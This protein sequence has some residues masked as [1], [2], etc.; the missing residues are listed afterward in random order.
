MVRKRG[1]EIHSYKEF[2]VF[3]IGERWLKKKMNIILKHFT[4]LSSKVV[5]IPFGILDQEGEVSEIL[6]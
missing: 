5:I 4:D 6:F 3:N 1:L 2:T